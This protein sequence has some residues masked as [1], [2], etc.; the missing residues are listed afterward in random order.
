MIQEM[1]VGMAVVLFVLGYTE[2]ICRKYIESMG[3]PSTFTGIY[4]KTV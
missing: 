4:V 1:L 3:C 2:Y